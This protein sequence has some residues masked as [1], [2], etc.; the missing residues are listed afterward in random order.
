MIRINYNEA[1]PL[2]GIFVHYQNVSKNNYFNVFGTKLKNIDNVQDPISVTQRDLPQKYFW[3]SDSTD[4]SIYFSFRHSI[5]LQRYCL[6]NA[7]SEDVT[8]SYPREFILYFSHDNT[9]WEELDHQKQQKFCDSNRC[10]ASNT[11]NYTIP[12]SKSVFA[13]YFRIKSIENSLTDE[14]YLILRYVEFFGLIRYYDD[15]FGTFIISCP[16]IFIM[17]LFASS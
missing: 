13:N 4:K 17:T 1:A 10:G 9:T 11:L 12:E 7:A 2:D 3:A 5:L 6:T 15:T 8:H 14:D 16:K